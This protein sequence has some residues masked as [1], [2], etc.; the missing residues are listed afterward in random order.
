MLISNFFI[1]ICHHLLTCSNHGYCSDVGT[2]QCDNG[3]YSD[4]CS[5]KFDNLLMASSCNS[6]NFADQSMFWIKIEKQI[7]QQNIIIEMKFVSWIFL[8]FHH[9]L[10]LKLWQQRN[11]LIISWCFI[12]FKTFYCHKIFFNSIK[13]T[14]KS[15][16]LWAVMNTIV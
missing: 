1:A 11:I 6:P 3:F 10:Y 2:C 5:S 15:L 7:L 4:D 8:A 12:C 14:Y 16:R 13:I 9:K